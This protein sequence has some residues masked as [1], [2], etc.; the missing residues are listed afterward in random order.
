MFRIVLM[1]A[2]IA[3]LFCTSAVT[4]V[5][6]EEKATRILD[7]DLRDADV[8]MR[9]MA[10]RGTMRDKLDGGAWVVMS[11]LAQGFGRAECGLDGA[12]R[13]LVEPALTSLSV[14]EVFELNRLVTANYRNAQF[15]DR[16]IEVDV[17][18]LYPVSFVALVQMTKQV[19]KGRQ[20]AFQID[21][22]KV[23]GI[24]QKAKIFNTNRNSDKVQ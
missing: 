16:E 8:A 21:C 15:G 20:M 6:A 17:K 13:W 1:N 11:T 12:G 19:R 14:D 4:Q 24:W 23:S 5:H 2:A 18:K 7:L 22:A 9:S 3:F 10:L